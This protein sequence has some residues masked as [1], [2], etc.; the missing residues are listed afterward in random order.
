M[1]AVASRYG[2]TLVSR[3]EEQRVRGSTLVICLT[4]EEA[5]ADA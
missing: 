5:L 2:T 1:M 4:P 3:D